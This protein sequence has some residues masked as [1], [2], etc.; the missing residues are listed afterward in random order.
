[1]KVFLGLMLTMVTV[2]MASVTFCHVLIWRRELL[3]DMTSDDEKEQMEDTS[4]QMASCWLMLKLPRTWMRCKKNNKQI[5]VQLNVFDSVYVGFFSA[6]YNTV[7]ITRILCMR[8]MGTRL[9]ANKVE[10]RG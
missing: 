3:P 4:K 1:M 6:M 5:D 7:E 9:Y 2:I 10:P 8:K